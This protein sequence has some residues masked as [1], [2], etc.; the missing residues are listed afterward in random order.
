M[1]TALLTITFLC[2]F[3]FSAPNLHAQDEKKDAIAKAL[4]D[5][6]FL[7]R[8]NIHVQLNKSIYTTN[9]QIW[10]KGYVFHRKKN[11]PFFTTVNIYTGSRY[12]SFSNAIA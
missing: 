9:E 11:I 1:K 2:L 4:N 10:F 6:F 7:E 8:E 12:R 5:Y 3:L